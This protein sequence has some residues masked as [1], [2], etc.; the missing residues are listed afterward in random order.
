M[1]SA[2]VPEEHGGGRLTLLDSAKRSS[3]E[4]LEIHAESEETLNPG[5]TR[6]LRRR[7]SLPANALSVTIS[8]EEHI[9]TYE[10]AEQMRLLT[11]R[12]KLERDVQ[13]LAVT[14]TIAGEGSS[15]V[16]RS[17]ATVL[18][19]D[20]SQR[21]CLL[22]FNWDATGTVESANDVSVLGIADH[23]K[24]DTGKR[25]TVVTSGEVAPLQRSLYATSDALHEDIES[26]RESFDVVILDLPAVATHSGVL[27]LSEYA[28]RYLLV[29]RQGVAPVE[30]VR[31]AIE[32][33]GESYLAGVVLNQ[34]TFDS[35]GWLTRITGT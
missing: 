22:E 21:V 12:S 1:T 23:G 13:C 19:H 20:S 25:L 26:F 9:V 10:V 35:P 18:A 15:Y 24:D 5:R 31:A 27:A 11:A 2:I 34:A 33:L 16:A 4:A 17:L 8:G 7:R 32:D 6:F 14:S 3:S 29:A 28:D 30:S